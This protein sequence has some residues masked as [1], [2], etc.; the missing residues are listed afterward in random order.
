MSPKTFS[1]GAAREICEPVFEKNARLPAI[2]LAPTD[3]PKPPCP[4]EP[5]GWSAAAG[6]SIGIAVLVLVA[7]GG[8]E[9]HVVAGGVEHGLLLERRGAFAADRQ[10]DDL[11]A[12]VDRV[13]DRG[14]LVDIA[15]AVARADWH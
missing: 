10:I 8:D 4:F 11:G 14:G 7:R 9:E 13:D 1:P 3:R 6:Y 15:E 5:G 2:V 12:V